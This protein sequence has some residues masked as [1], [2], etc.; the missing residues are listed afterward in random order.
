MTDRFAIEIVDLHKQF[1]RQTA[2]QGLNLQVREGEI[3]SLL[4]PNGAGKSTTISILSG[5]I[6]PT[7]G[8]VTLMGHPL[9]TQAN[10]ARASLGV[11]PQDIALYPDLS[12][13][14]NLY[15]WGRM[16]GLRGQTLNQRVADVMEL[17]GLS[18]RQK[19]RVGTF[20]GGMKRRVNIGAALLH[21]P[22]IVVLDEPTVGIDPQSRRHILDSV[23]ELNRLGATVL[24]TTH[25]MEEA[26]E[27]SDHIAIMDQGRLIAQGTHAE[28]TQLV[29]EQTRLVLTLSQPPDGVLEVWRQLPGVQQVWTEAE[30]VHLLVGDSTAVLPHLFET[31][32]QAHVH[33]VTVSIQEPNLEAVFLHLTGRALRDS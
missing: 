14:E 21:H 27:L 22:D 3:F 24:Y 20:S 2:V 13:R 5:L 18:E 7:R 17:I 30:N 26:E 23:K 4:G 29:G 10:Q 16:Y 19:D 6:A 12:A 32:A 1:G 28:L 33:I 11:V 8:E 9:R 15:F 25:Y 31:A